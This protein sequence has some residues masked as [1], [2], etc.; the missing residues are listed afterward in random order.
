MNNDRLPGALSYRPTQTDYPPRSCPTTQQKRK[1]PSTPQKTE[2]M[3]KIKECCKLLRE[4]ARAE[5]STDKR[6]FLINQITKVAALLPSLMDAERQGLDAIPPQKKRKIVSEEEFI[7]SSMDFN[8][9]VE[10]FKAY[11]AEPTEAN[12]RKMEQLYEAFCIYATK[13]PIPLK[14]KQCIQGIAS[15]CLGD[16]TL[17]TFQFAREGHPDGVDRNTI[18]YLLFL[19]PNNPINALLTK[20]GKIIKIEKPIELDEI[21]G[22]YADVLF[23]FLTNEQF[24]FPSDLDFKSIFV[25]I[26]KTNRFCLPELVAFCGEKLIQDLEFGTTVSRNALTF[27][28]VA[29]MYQLKAVQEM[30][31][32]Y[33]ENIGLYPSNPTFKEYFVTETFFERDEVLR[34]A[35]GDDRK[36]QEDVVGLDFNRL[37]EDIQPSQLQG[38]AEVFPNVTQIYLPL[39]MSICH[40]KKEDLQHF[41]QLKSINFQTRIIRL[42]NPDGGTDIAAQVNTD[43]VAN[44]PRFK[45]LIGNYGISFSWIN[46]DKDDLYEFKE[47]LAER[48]K[49]IEENFSEQ[50]EN[51]CYKSVDDP[52]EE[53]RDM[54]SEDNMPETVSLMDAWSLSRPLPRLKSINIQAMTSPAELDLPKLCPNL[55]EL[56]IQGMNINH[57]ALENLAQEC[58]GIVKIHIYTPHGNIFQEDGAL[59]KF[60]LLE[61]LIVHKPVRPDIAIHELIPHLPSLKELIIP[62]Y[63]FSTKLE[64]AASRTGLKISSV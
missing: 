59:T 47:F 55:T 24:T 34:S 60:T 62:K 20:D 50:I 7:N 21:D 18:P 56:T 28:A 27:Y 30:A 12:L 57:P 8:Q 37:D 40:L 61:N 14:T 48:K 26:E 49:A 64:S 43:E 51:V 44:D 29:A 17:V 16:K 23:D 19:N 15:R 58:K 9:H 35:S 25:L 36:F 39:K 5:S 46:F 1:A 31:A 54:E 41:K 4:Q 6:A 22:K 38:L 53:Q 11:G 45:E 2:E 10:A 42:V 13:E 3:R 52:Q 32:L 33:L 63:I